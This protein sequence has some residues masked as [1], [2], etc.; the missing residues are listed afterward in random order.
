MNFATLKTEKHRIESILVVTL[1]RPAVRNAINIEMMRELR[2][3][4][5]AIFINPNA[6]RCIILTGSEG[7]FCAGADL[8]ERKNMNL[9]VWHSQHAVLQ[10]AMLAMLDCPVPIISAVN[11]AA[12][13]GGL[14][15]VL[16]SDFA[17]AS[18]KA[19]FGQSEVKL[20]IMPGALG[21]QNLPRACGLKRA[22]ELCFTA[23]SF[24]AINAYEWGIINRV[25]EPEELM[26][27]VLATAEKIAMNAPLAVREVK[28]ALNMS[29][30]LDIKSGY[31]FEVE[32]Y[33]RLLPTEDREEGINAFNEKRKPAFTG[34]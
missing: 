6:W 3:F 14:E 10:Q 31:A 19:V 29:Q 15:L 17:Y 30:Q 33:N 34:K 24:S 28:K 11:G 21:T 13:G 23:E 2:Q 25:C 5:Q 22:K 27:E 9:D 1:N 32:A 26:R 20:G 12:F 8:K 18:T 7:A 4:W 16:A